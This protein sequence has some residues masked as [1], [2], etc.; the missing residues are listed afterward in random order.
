M[1]CPVCGIWNRKNYTH[2]F[3]CG[4]PLVQEQ[5]DDRQRQGDAP[6]AEN[7]APAAQKTAYRSINAADAPKFADDPFFS[8]VADD[9][10]P[11]QDRR[12][13]R[14]FFFSHKYSDEDEQ[15]QEQASDADLKEDGE[16]FSFRPLEQAE[17][18]PN[19]EAETA[20]EIGA[21]EPEPAAQEERPAQKKKHGPEESY[22]SIP[23]KIPD[24]QEPPANDFSEFEENTALFD[25]SDWDE[26]NAPEPIQEQPPVQETF[27]IDDEPRLPL[28]EQEE[29]PAEQPAEEYTEEP[30]QEPEIAAELPEEPDQ[31][32]KDEA[33]QAAPEQAPVED[34]LGKT[35]HFPPIKPGASQPQQN[36]EVLVPA[37]A[38]TKTQR[39]KYADS[40][41]SR[42][43]IQA[44]NTTPVSI[45]E[46]IAEPRP[47]RLMSISRIAA[48]DRRMPLENSRTEPKPESDKPEPLVRPLDEIPASER[49]ME[50]GGEPFNM[51]DEIS[52]TKPAREIIHKATEPQIVFTPID[53]ADR[54][55]LEASEEDNL[56]EPDKENRFE[57]MVKDAQA[58]KPLTE[59]A[60]Q[61]VEEP[62]AETIEEASAPEA[63]VQA[64]PEQE[65]QPEWAKE[66]LRQLALNDAPLP[67]RSRGEYTYAAASYEG[68]QRPRRRTFGIESSEPQQTQPK[69]ARKTA[70]APAR[71]SSQTPRY[72]SRERQDEAYVQQRP[73]AR[74]SRTAPVRA[75]DQRGGYTGYVPSVSAS[76]RQNVPEANRPRERSAA[77][78]R[79][80]QAPS[81]EQP[82][83]SSA[84]YS[85]PQR[86]TAARDTS[87]SMRMHSSRSQRPQQ[88]EP[89]RKMNMPAKRKG[90]V[91]DPIRLAIS[92]LVAL[93]VLGLLIWGVVAGI[94]GIV[95]LF[96]KDTPPEQE[97]Q[98]QTQQEEVVDENAPVVSEA[99]VNGNPGHSITFKGNDGDI[100]YIGEPIND[101][102]NIVGGIGVLEIEDSK[103][104]GDQITNQ[105][106]TITL[107]P[108]LRDG[109]SG[110]ETQLN[111]I[112]LVVTPPDA[113]LEILTPASGREEVNISS[114]QLKFRV[115]IGS[116]V[117]V[118]GNDVS[119]LISDQ[120]DNAGIVIVNVDVE[121]IGDNVIPI[122]VNKA[123][124]KETTKNVILYRAER[125]I[126]IELSPDTPTESTSKTVKISGV[127]ADGASIEVTSGIDGEVEMQSDGSFSF[128][129][130]LTKFGKN[131][132]TIIA[133][134]DGVQDIPF[135][136][137]ITYNPTADDYT[138]LCRTMDYNNLLNN[139]GRV[140]ECFGE[141]TEILND[142]SNGEPFTFI[143]NVGTSSTPQYIYM[144]MI[145]K[146][147]YPTTGTRY[148]ICA[149]VVGQTD[150]GLPSMMAR[151]WYNAR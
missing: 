85:R 72:E 36:V 63:S 55:P 98:A 94:K 38:L 75:S 47:R 4:A 81:R 22:F 54:K 64:E 86:D 69:E 149:D 87:A 99:T 96:H 35:R 32:V 59:A 102:V 139:V 113:N 104:I 76:A 18:T 146:D 71:Q 140:Y 33:E 3:R 10:A 95:G 16:D 110:K 101:N 19:L 82:R 142:G 143:Y 148:K 57:Q 131:E 105:D 49:E 78:E 114:Y 121:P 26:E 12:N 6:A 65:E 151:Y 144:E 34:E 136:H 88:D 125:E 79:Y 15:A 147:S 13:L 14:S 42:E 56:P 117:T 127:V 93:L 2:C 68:E 67:R 90:R 77:G 134:K 129:A 126:A 80:A 133:S 58:E 39:T 52:P 25:Y 17:E 89:I 51:K 70:S 107:I 8:D 50:L 45:Q 66:A 150:D 84:G 120:A 62:A 9:P 97:Q 135:T 44:I 132:V 106:V 11:Q 60:A 130:K 111:P 124:C 21:Q 92:L 1:K 116:T 91:R 20:E 141:I 119:D 83:S 128:K 108:V 112:E 37:Q 115:D 109:K 53:A 40:E 103:L 29:F 27:A 23:L 138:R 48:G 43:I 123:G 5:D 28:E 61:P 7:G 137:V 122:T 100:V 46:P 31:P 118:A 74:T 41:I 24:R 73:Q 145:K 30:A